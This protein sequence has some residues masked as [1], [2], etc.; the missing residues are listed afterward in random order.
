MLGA[1][2][3]AHTFQGSPSMDVLPSDEGVVLADVD[4]VGCMRSASGS[5]ASCRTMTEDDGSRM[6]ISSSSVY[7]AGI[8]FSATMLWIDGSCV[9]HPFSSHKLDAGPIWL[10]TIVYVFN[11]YMAVLRDGV[12]SA[13][14]ISDGYGHFMGPKGGRHVSNSINAD[15]GSVDLFGGIGGNTGRVS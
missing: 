11:Y 8:P 9:L 2:T 1:S 15:I 5:Q 12:K 14:R 6:G 7:S 3:V 4:S 10:L 13:I